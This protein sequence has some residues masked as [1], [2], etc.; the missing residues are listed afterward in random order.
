MQGDV[1]RQLVD[2]L[3][4]LR[5][6][7]ILHGLQHLAR[8]GGKLFTQHLLVFRLRLMCRGRWS[9][10]RTPPP[11]HPLLRVLLHLLPRRV[12]LEK[13]TDGAAID[14]VITL[15]TRSTSQR[16]RGS[17]IID[18]DCRS[19]QP[20]RIRPALVTVFWPFGGS[21]FVTTWSAAAIHSWSCC[22]H[23]RSRRCRRL[24]TAP[25]SRSPWLSMVPARASATGR[26]H[27]CGPTLN[28]T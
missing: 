9:S 24:I 2:H 25:V 15:W 28:K 10:A 18:R 23:E 1:F 14:A 3:G 4:L 8:L 11:Q 16:H 21:F 27:Y 13:V 17:Y 20:G 22:H 19:S 12:R 6:R 26:I 5:L 7:R